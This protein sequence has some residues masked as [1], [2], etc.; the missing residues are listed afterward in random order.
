MVCASIFL[1]IMA[2]TLAPFNAL[3]QAHLRI[4]CNILDGH[5]PLL[6]IREL[7]S[8]EKREISWVVFLLGMSAVVL[9]FGY[10]ARFIFLMEQSHNHE[11]ITQFANDRGGP[12]YFYSQT[13][14]FYSAC[15]L[16]LPCLSVSSLMFWPFVSSFSTRLQLQ[17]ATTV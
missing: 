14:V 11:S 13:Q 16:T 1:A 9:F 3:R 8:Q 17:G 6:Q 10:I 12:G 5:Q 2:P 4:H 7:P 15:L